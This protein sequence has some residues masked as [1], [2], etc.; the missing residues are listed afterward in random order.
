MMNYY[1]K[2]SVRFSLLAT[3]YVYFNEDRPPVPIPTRTRTTVNAPGPYLLPRTF[4]YEHSMEKYDRIVAH[5]SCCV[6]HNITL[7]Q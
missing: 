7:L 2:I 3:D 1:V 4:T 6:T 5:V